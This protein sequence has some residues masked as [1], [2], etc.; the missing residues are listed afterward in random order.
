M[1]VLPEFGQLP[2]IKISNA[3][4][5]G[6]SR[7]AACDW[8]DAVELSRDVQGRLPLCGNSDGRSTVRWCST[9]CI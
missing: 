2:L 6:W 4:I 5:R 9:H 1:Q 3:A 7:S 8:V